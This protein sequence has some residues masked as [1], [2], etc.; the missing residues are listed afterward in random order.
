M[1]LNLQNKKVFVSGSSSG[2]GLEIAKN[3]VQEGATVIINGRNQ[4]K[5]ELAAKEIQCFDLVK[6]DVSIP[7][8]ASKV[9]S[10]VIEKLSGIDILVCNVGSG[11]SVS[12]GKETFEEWHRVFA[13]NF[14]SSTNLI[15]ASVSALEESS[16]AIVCISSICGSETIPER[17]YLFCCEICLEYLCKKRFLSFGFKGHKDKLCLSREYKF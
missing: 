12:P 7:E 8:E 17:N 4:K 13:I 3:F 5:L 2:I 11:S 10:Y 6:G 16:G 9:I 15:E 14:F 1:N